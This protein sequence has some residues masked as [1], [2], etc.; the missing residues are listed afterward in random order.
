MNAYKKYGSIV[1]GVALCVSLIGC[2]A[3]AGGSKDASSQPVAAAEKTEAASV[4]K[5]GLG[6]K[7]TYEVKTKPD[8]NAAD[9]DMTP[10]ANL[11]V[12]RASDKVI[13]NGVQFN[14]DTASGATPR[15]VR[16]PNEIQVDQDAKNK[17]MQWTIQ[18]PLGIVEGEFYRATKDFAGGY[19]ATTDL[20]IDKGN[21]VHVE[22]NERGPKDYYEKR[23][24]DQ[25]KRRSGYGF[26]QASSPRTHETLMVTPNAFNYLEWQILKYNSLN[27]TPQ[28]VRGISNSA[29]EA[30]IPEIQ[31]L[32]KQV[33]QKSNKYYTAVALPL[34]QGLTG[35][36]ELIHEGD[37]IVEVRYDEIFADRAEDIA[38]EADK[39]WYRQSKLESVDY[40][41]E[42]Q[43]K[44]R[45]FNDALGKAIMAANSLDFELPEY[46]D[47]PE[48]KNAQMFA[49][50][51]KPVVEA[52]RANG[53]T[54]EVGNLTKHPEGLKDITPIYYRTENLNAKVQDASY[55]PDKQILTVTATVKNND[56]KPV[57]VQSDWFFIYLKNTKGKQESVGDPDKFSTKIEGN[58][59]AAVTMHF[60]PVYDTDTE[61]NFKYDGPNKSYEEMKPLSK[62]TKK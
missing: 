12:D 41:I 42:N 35:R 53:Y 7:F 40:N 47:M 34:E 44:F 1:C 9:V 46:Q 49:E 24:A 23:W 21:V 20:V 14:F 13:Y 26:F 52:Y 51:L 16:T 18:P 29:R 50:K 58:A 57:E 56:S 54:H 48:Y 8:Y 10:N 31:E 15:Y 39:K 11:A 59:E 17:R 33:E 61:L 6:T 4:G 3:P 2:Q 55:D 32:A 45:K 60:F 5:D 25:T 37:K 43:D 28:G 36:L 30:F 22:M 62:L 38:N 19:I 27:F